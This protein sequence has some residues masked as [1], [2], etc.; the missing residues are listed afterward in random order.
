MRG[1]PRHFL[2]S[3]LM[4]WVALD[5]AV[6]LAAGA[7]SRRRRRRWERDGREIRRAILEEG[8]DREVGAFT[9]T[10]GGS[11]ARR[12]R[13]RHPARRFLP[14][15]GPARA[16][17]PPS[18]YASDSPR[19]GLVYRYLNDD[20]LPGGE[21]TFALCSFWLVDNLAL[22][23]RVD[24]AR[25][26]FE[27]VAGYAN[28]LGLLAEEIDPA[29]GE[30][31]GNFPQGFSHSALIRSALNI[32]RAEALGPEEQAE[33]QAERASKMEESGQVSGALPRPRP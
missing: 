19:G 5:R 17:R 14:G 7:R 16:S 2:Y 31:L 25:E 3:K 6:R 8:Y 11:G 22:Q 21:A 33:N 18:G 1:G 24:E 12:Q 10:L 9:Q 32:S 20:G 27:R 30:L 28:D 15:Y 29:S 23:G 26:L 4:C 13:A